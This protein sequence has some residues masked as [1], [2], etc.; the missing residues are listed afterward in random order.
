MSFLE[1]IKYIFLGFIQGFTEPIPV[2]SSGH[3]LIFQKLVSGD[4]FNVDFSL[5]ATLTNFGSLIAISIIY[6]EDIV[7][8]FKSF[9]SYLKT[10]KDE[11]YD[12]YKYCWL[13]VIGTIPAGIMGLVVTKLDL[14]T[15]LEE[16]VKFVGVTL[17]ITAVFLFLIRN[18]KGK[19]TKKDITFKDA[20]IVGLFQVVALIPGISRS[21]A[22]IVGGMTR[23]FKRE[24]AF[25]FSFI[26]YIPI[27][28]ATT[29]L[30]ISDLL[31]S[32]L[33]LEM[34]IYYISATIVSGFI[35]FF[36]TKWFRNI[37]KH[38]KLIYFVI[39]C[40]IVGSLVILFL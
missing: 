26:L 15:K 24:T 11:H 28:I 30:G 23:K 3:L 31:G 40:L 20:I 39:Y 1:L 19:K 8:L 29:I 38:G 37:V 17:L 32:N 22:T 33:S 27:S 7:N 12:N 34:W 36:A 21:G 4:N 2:S 16:N 5:L 6:R 18:I 10:K 35:T 14:F 9:F 13:I 25:D